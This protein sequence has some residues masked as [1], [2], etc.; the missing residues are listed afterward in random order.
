MNNKKR[1]E[2]RRF[3][4]FTMIEILIVVVIL[5]ISALV[6]VPMFSSAADMQVRSAANM[7]AADLDYARGLAIT[8]QKNYTLVFAPSTESYQLKD[9]AGTVI[10]NPVNGGSFTVNFSS[11]S[12]LSQVNIVT[13]NFDS[14]ASNAVTFNYLGT[15]YRG[16]GTST[17]LNA[18]RITLTAGD[19]TLYVD[20]EPMTGYV[21]IN[22]S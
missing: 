17:V 2:N 21:T 6:A 15:P 3:I 10:T 9:S 20:V 8:R 7:I 11:E 12:R 19:F 5:A 13:A 14:D 16:T 4:G 22:E 1:I 18:G